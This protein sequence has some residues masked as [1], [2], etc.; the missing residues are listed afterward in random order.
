MLAV[1]RFVFPPVREG[2][3]QYM[4][5]VLRSGVGKEAWNAMS[6]KASLSVLLIVTFALPLPLSAAERHIMKPR[7]PA[8][9]L[10]E[11]RALSSPLPDSPDTSE[12]GQHLY[13]GK[14]ACLNCH[15]YTGEGDGPVA[16]E[17]KP[18]PRDFHDRGF[19]RQRTEGE[20]F[21][22]IKHGVKGTSMIGFGDQLSD[23]EIWSIVRYLRGFAD[24]QEP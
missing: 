1:R 2:L 18:P 22:V 20:I 3:C 7:V 6:V 24:Q 8:E 4:A 5:T 15:G 11:A 9:R 21:W 12:K 14:G 19:W 17:L 16:A 10:A 13:E 23:K